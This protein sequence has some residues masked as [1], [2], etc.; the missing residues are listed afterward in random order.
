[1]C[2]Y[3]SFEKKFYY[4]VTWAYFQKSFKAWERGVQKYK[5]GYHQP[6]YFFTQEKA[7]AAFSAENRGSFR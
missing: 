2:S 4:C 3:R 5:V 6:R 1:M 7:L